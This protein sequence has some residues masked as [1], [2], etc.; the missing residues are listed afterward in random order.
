MRNGKGIPMMTSEQ[1]AQ[2][3]LSSDYSRSMERPG[4]STQ[5][6]KSFSRISELMKKGMGADEA[7]LNVSNAR[8]KEKSLESSRKIK[9]SK[10]GN[11]TEHSSR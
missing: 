8:S 1:L 10:K 3:A 7:M 2:E 11:I 9:I 4:G 5:E 6:R